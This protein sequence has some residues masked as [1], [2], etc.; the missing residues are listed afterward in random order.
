[1]RTIT[2]RQRHEKVTAGVTDPPQKHE[3]MSTKKEARAIDKYID[4]LVEK[5]EDSIREAIMDEK[6][7]A[8]AWVNTPMG[9]IEVETDNTDDVKVYVTH[10]NGS[11]HPCPNLC[12]MVDESIIA[13]ADVE[14][15]LREDSLYG[16]GG[17][18]EG[19]DP[20][21]SSWQDYYNYRYR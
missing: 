1:M 21:F 19:L 10:D 2:K 6:N 17:K 3:A 4:K 14:E 20:A 18:Y 11:E 7:S 5:L 13:W 12:K 15:S 8:S 16:P 9:V